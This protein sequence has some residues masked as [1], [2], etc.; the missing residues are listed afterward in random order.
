VFAEVIA[1]CEQAGDRLHLGAAYANRAWLWG[2]LGKVER[3]HD[4]L[5]RVIQIAREL[6]Q[7]TLERIGTHNLAEELLWE[8]AL[9]EALPMARRCY[10]IQRAHGEATTIPDRMLLSRV[11]AARGDDAELAEVL[12]TL[13][14]DPLSAEDAVVVACLR[15]HWQVLAEQ[16]ELLPP[17]IRIE[18]AHLAV[19]AGR[20]DAAIR[21]TIRELARTHP[22]WQRR[23]DEL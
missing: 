2:E 3:T 9:D 6:G 11:L 10:A 8:G 17:P 22:I 23:L 21:G 13:A 5:R 18:V 4:D 19:R 1:E 7:A 20:L 15:G 12:N 16:G 14:A